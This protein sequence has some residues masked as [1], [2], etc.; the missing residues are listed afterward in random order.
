MG[1]D[2]YS[3]ETRDGIC[4]EAM[5]LAAAKRAATIALLGAEKGL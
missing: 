2:P 1:R 4:G 5:T 3:W